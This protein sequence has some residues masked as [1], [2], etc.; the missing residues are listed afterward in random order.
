VEVFAVNQ[1]RQA[2]RHRRSNKKA[3]MMRKPLQ[4]LFWI[5]AGF[6]LGLFMTE[7]PALLPLPQP[8]ISEFGFFFQVV[9]VAGVCLIGFCFFGLFALA[10]RD[11]F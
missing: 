1:Y 3:Q 8:F 10:L 9:Q 6:L 11:A 5:G 4:D 7:F 2:P